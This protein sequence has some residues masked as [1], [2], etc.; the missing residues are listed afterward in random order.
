MTQETARILV[1]DHRGQELAARASFLAAGNY[2]L[3]HS[4][5][6]RE[7]VRQIE[8]ARPGVILL[9]PLTRGGLEELEALD[10][11]RRNVP[12]LV[13][14]ERDDRSAPLRVAR[15]LI[16]GA[17]DLVFRDAPDEELV[18]RIERLLAHSRLQDEMGALRHSASHDDRTDLL[19]V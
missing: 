12:A 3:A 19:R 13:L 7:T 4:R 18:L 16:T 10:L 15:A 14:C 1:A 17:F 5:S 6:L 9:D 2:E 8:A 11:A